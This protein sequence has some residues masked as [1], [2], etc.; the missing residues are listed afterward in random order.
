MSD[1]TIIPD[2][3]ESGHGSR[4][5]SPSP[6]LDSLLLKLRPFQRAAFEFAVHGDDTKQSEHENNS[7]A[8]DQYHRQEVVVP[9]AGAGTGRIL[10]G[11]EMGLGCALLFLVVTMILHFVCVFVCPHHFFHFIHLYIEGKH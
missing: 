3:T 7:K 9:V 8:N 1:D 6:H 2:N 10:L 11:D 5:S 4:R